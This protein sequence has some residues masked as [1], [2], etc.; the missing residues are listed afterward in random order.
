MPKLL[1]LEDD[2]MLADT[3]KLEFKDRNYDCYVANKISKIP[4]I[5]FDYAIIDIRLQG[6]IGLDSIEKLLS[7]NKDC[8]IL[9][10]TGYASITTAVEAIK[11]GAINYIMKPAS[12]KQLEEALINT[13]APDLKFQERPKLSQ[14]EQEYIDYVLSQNKGNV[15]KA[16]KDLGIHRQSLQRKLKKY[17]NFF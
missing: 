8:K 12:I 10:Q 7:L 15:S 4:E 16:A 9:V 14:L 6:E 1:I 5:A 3:L 11:R 17:T 2:L 13:N